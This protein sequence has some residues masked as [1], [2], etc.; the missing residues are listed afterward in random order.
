MPLAPKKKGGGKIL[1]GEKYSVRTG[2][3]AKI[4][5]HL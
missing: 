3:I 2:K 5:E 1:G 4:V